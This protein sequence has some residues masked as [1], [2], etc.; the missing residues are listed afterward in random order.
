MFTPTAKFISKILLDSV[1]ENEFACHLPS[2]ICHLPSA[3]TLTW[4]HVGCKIDFPGRTGSRT[5]TRIMHAIDI[6]RT[7]G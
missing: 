1:L 6:L 3:I 5:D 7:D 2:A 4:I